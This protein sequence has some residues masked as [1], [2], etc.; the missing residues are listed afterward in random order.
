MPLLAGVK[1]LL[2]A[3]IFLHFFRQRLGFDGR[4]VIR[5]LSEVLE[6]PFYSCPEQ[7]WEPAEF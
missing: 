2:R 4:G 6:I 7:V 3:K 1:I 5:G